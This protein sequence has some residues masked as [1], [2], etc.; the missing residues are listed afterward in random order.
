MILRRG[1]DRHALAVAE[2]QQADL[3]ARHPF[4][5]EDLAPGL[6]ETRFL[7]QHRPDC[8]LGFGERVGQ[9]DAFAGGQAGRFH[10]R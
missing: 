10:H 3:R 4:L 7:A 2:R 6:A 1:H 5:D 9:V 8:V